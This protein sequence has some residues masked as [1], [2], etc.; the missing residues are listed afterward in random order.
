MTARPETRS[1]TRTRAARRTSPCCRHPD[2]PATG[3]CASC[4]RERLSSLDLVAAVGAP[5]APSPELRRCRSVVT[6]P[7]FEGSTSGRNEPRRKSCEA[8]SDRSSL[9]TLFDVDD[10]RSG[11]EEGEARVESKNVGKHAGFS[12]AASAAI[13]LENNNGDE[14]RVSSHKLGES[15]A[16]GADGDGDIQGRDFK[17]MKEYID[18]EFQNKAKKSKDLRDKITGNLLGAASVFTRRLLSWRQNNNTNQVKNQKNHMEGRKSGNARNPEISFDEPRASWDE[19]MIARTIPR[20]APMLSVVEHGILGGTNKFESH[21]LS[22]DGPMHS[23]VEDESTSG[24]SG[25]GHSNSDSSFTMRRS[26]F[27]QSSSV[28]SFG[29][30]PSG[31][32]DHDNVKL[33]ITEKEL[34]DWRLNDGLENVGPVYGNGNI[35]AANIENA[36]KKSVGWRK[37]CYAFGFGRKCSDNHNKHSDNHNKHGGPGGHMVVGPSFYD[38]REVGPLRE[39]VPR[40]ARS[41]SVVGPR[42][43]CDSAESNCRRSVDGGRGFYGLNGI[44]GFELEKDAEFGNRCCSDGVGV[45]IKP[46]YMT[47]LRSLKHSKSRKLKL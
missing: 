11:S 13:E 43:S 22:V 45:G 33:V 34:K 14:I 27:D 20:L 42:N 1:R 30:K 32:E 7:K 17:T 41:V 36:A 31:S 29:K 28:R 40:L 15:S 37:A 4:L 46:F 35:N 24:A 6:F 2:E 21:R 19:Y 25:S 18:L 23:I 3:I 8:A 47:P 5:S 44:E 16:D 10:L 26:S 39:C 38:T 9:C 12:K